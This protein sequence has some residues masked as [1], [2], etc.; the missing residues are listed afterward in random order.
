M[1]ALGKKIKRIARCIQYLTKLNQKTPSSK[2]RKF[3]KRYLEK[4]LGF[5]TGRVD[6]LSFE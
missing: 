1:K 6:K 3:G 4:S 5:S 2:T